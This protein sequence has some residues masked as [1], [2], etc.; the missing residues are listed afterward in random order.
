[1]LQ[2][3][4]L[5]CHIIFF[6]KFN[7]CSSLQILREHIPRHDFPVDQGHSVPI[8]YGETFFYLYLKL[9]VKRFQSLCHVQPDLEIFLKLTVQIGD[10]IR[11]TPSAHCASGTGDFMQSL[12]SFV[13]SCMVTCL[14]ML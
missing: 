1:M 10:C 14:L 2:P 12:P 5:F 3:T 9:I 11:K 8:K 4:D 7:I 13:I 6:V